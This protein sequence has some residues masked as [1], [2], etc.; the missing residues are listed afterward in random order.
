MEW[1]WIVLWVPGMKIAVAG[2]ITKVGHQVIHRGAVLRGHLLG[3]ELMKDVGWS[4]TMTSRQMLLQRVH[5][6]E[7]THGHGIHGVDL[8]GVVA[9]IG[10]M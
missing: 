1:K 2:V 8:L 5:G 6:G 3:C 4:S 7:A 10:S 9:E